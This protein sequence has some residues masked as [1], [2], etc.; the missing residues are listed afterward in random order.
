MNFGLISI[1]NVLISS[2][3][4]FRSDS[5]YPENFSISLFQQLS[6]FSCFDARIKDEAA[7]YD[8]LN[9]RREASSREIS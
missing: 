4:S 3:H 6:F 9:L 1:A 5:L 7:S 8:G 2:R